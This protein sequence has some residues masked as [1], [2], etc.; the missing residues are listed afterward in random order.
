MALPTPTPEQR[1]AA[2]EKGFH[3][4]G[5]TPER[6]GV[7]IG[8]GQASLSE[9]IQRWAARVQNSTARLVQLRWG[10]YPTSREGRG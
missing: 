5:F 3:G 8:L 1:A 7:A 9:Q 2:L 10:A 6:A 4:V